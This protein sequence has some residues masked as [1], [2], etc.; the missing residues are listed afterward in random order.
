MQTLWKTAVQASLGAFLCGASIFIAPTS[1]SATCAA[2]GGTING[3]LECELAAGT[4]SRQGVF[5]LTETLRM[6]AGAVIEVPGLL[7]GNFLTITSP[8]DIILEAGS[9]INGPSTGNSQLSIS[10][11][12]TLIADFDND[13]AG[14]VFIAGPSA[15]Q[16]AAQVTANGI[17]GG[18]I[19]I[20]G[21]KV[22][23][24]GI[25]ESAGTASGSGQTNPGGGVITIDAKCDVLVTGRVSSI[26]KD[27]GPDLV[28]IEGG[29]V[30]QIFG[31]VESTG[32]A[33]SPTTNPICRG[34]AGNPRPDKSPNAV[35][36]VEVWAGDSLLIDAATPGRNGEVH[37]DRYKGGGQTAWIDLFARGPIRI[38]GK[39]TGDIFAVHAN[40]FVIGQVNSTNNRAGDIRVA[41]RDDIV[42]ASGLAIQADSDL[43]SGGDGGTIRVDS[44]LQQTLNTAFLTA[45]G[46]DGT[47]GALGGAINNRAFNETLTWQ[48]GDGNVQPNASGSISLTACTPPAI[49]T[50]GTNFNGEVPVLASQCGGAPTFAVYVVFPPCECLVIPCMCIDRASVSAN[51]QTLSLQG[52][53]FKVPDPNNPGQLKN[54]LKAVGFAPTCTNTPACVQTTVS[55]T[56]ETSATL[57]VPACAAGQNWFV[58]VGFENSGGPGVTPESWACTQ[59]PRQF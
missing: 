38:L 51:K 40:G 29:C 8:G 54:N 10:A 20:S 53:A 47:S 36:C 3:A 27:P 15:N 2:L 1:A 18:D 14:D 5:N 35:A 42:T 52:C 33:H 6:L 32:A 37:A 41:S 44:A 57:A 55:V 30:V 22:T 46:R 16:P 39:T 21:V 25:V 31:L 59:T 7:G 26:G 43:K 12:I 56:S 45:R 23:I 11:T 34:G 4:Y 17:Y 28:H 48:N 9:A 24:H 13:L 49:N 58:I 19:T 50:T